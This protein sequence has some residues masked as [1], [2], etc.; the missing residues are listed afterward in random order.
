MNLK[1]TLGG[2][3]VRVVV[4]GSRHTHPMYMA[5]DVPVGPLGWVKGP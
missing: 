1:Q 2:S 3:T 5:T 4:R